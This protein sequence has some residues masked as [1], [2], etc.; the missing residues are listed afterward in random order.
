MDRVGA[1]VV[2]VGSTAVGAGDEVALVAEEPE[3]NDGYTSHVW[4]WQKRLDNCGNKVDQIPAERMG[5]RQRETRRSAPLQH[6]D[7]EG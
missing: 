2:S 6:E 5:R 4:G 7:P 3:L 1:V